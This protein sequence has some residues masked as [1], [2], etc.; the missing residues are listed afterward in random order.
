MAAD[1]ND[2]KRSEISIKFLLQVVAKFDEHRQMSFHRRQRP[3]STGLVKRIIHLSPPPVILLAIC[4]VA[5]LTTARAATVLDP[6]PEPSS[7]LF[8]YAVASLGDVNGDSVPDYA[9]GAPFQDGDIVSKA[10]GFGY[11]QNVG[12]VFVIDGATFAILSEMD[13]PE[14]EVIQDQHF[15]GQ[16]GYSLSVSADINGDGIADLIAG[17]PHHISNPDDNDLNRSTPAK[18][19]FSA[20]RMAHFS[21]PFSDPAEQEEGRFGIAVAALGD[22]DGDGIADFVVGADGKDIGGGGTS[23]SSHMEQAPMKRK[24]RPTLGR[25]LFSAARLGL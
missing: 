10:T 2:P 19:L 21:L 17:V 15:G 24:G 5:C 9:V 12:K 7:T 25:L 6:D 20:A 22:V 11:P 1:R 14:F 18:P 16:L 4:A 3:R 23:S 13:D 8:G